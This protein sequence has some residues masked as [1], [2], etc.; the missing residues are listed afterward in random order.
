VIV[1]FID[2]YKSLFGVEP[3][4]RV[5]RDHNLQ[6]APSTYYAA[7][8][9]PPSARQ[10]SD[11]KRLED[12][13]RV[14]RENY[15]V[16]GVRKVWHALL[17]EGVQIGRD[18]VARLMRI[19]GLKGVTRRKSIR[20]TEPAP[21]DVR[22]PDLV[23]RDWFRDAPDVVWVTD[24]THVFTR[25]GWVYVSFLQDGYSR[26]ILG[27]TVATSKTT[28]LVSSALDQAVSVRRRSSDVA[29]VAD[30]LLVHSDAGSQY[31]SLA[32]SQKLH[33]HGLVGSIGRVGTAY[34]NALMESTIG[35]YKSEL[36]HFRATGW[37]SRQEV[38]TATARWVAWFNRV[39]LHG[40][41]GHQT[42]IEIEMAYAHQQG[43]PRQAA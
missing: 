5:L 40:E 11:E 21:L 14:H 12:V 7:K 24:F 36:I 4:C 43:Q 9:R 34:D 13:K 8:T 32:F 29:F 23:Q 41:L 10:V 31:T 15:G 22:P 30:G 38:E 39:R 20:T 26:H 37:T 18:Q 16:Y 35:L 25:E 17:R 19:A 3:I 2:A 33:D 27:F 1:A 28:A 6:V 42:P